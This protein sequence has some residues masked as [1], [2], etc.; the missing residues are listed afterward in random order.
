MKR[1]SHSQY[2]DALIKTGIIL[3]TYHAV[4]VVIGISIKVYLFPLRV[5]MQNPFLVALSLFVMY[6]LVLLLVKKTNIVKD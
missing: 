4:L 3:A 5:H 2:L 1:F 6:L